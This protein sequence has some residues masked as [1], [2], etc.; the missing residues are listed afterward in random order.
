[1]VKNGFGETTMT[2][3][4]PVTQAKLI[5]TVGPV[6]DTVFSRPSMILM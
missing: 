1:M 2:V 4:D 6:Y 5:I 3:L